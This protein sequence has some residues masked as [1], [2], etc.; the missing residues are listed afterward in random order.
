MK[1]KFTKQDYKNLAKAA[2]ALP[3]SIAVTTAILAITTKFIIF[4]WQL[5]Y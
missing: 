1:T 2:I 3:I 5:V 4:V